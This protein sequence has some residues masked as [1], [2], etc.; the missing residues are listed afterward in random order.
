MNGAVKYIIHSTPNHANTNLKRFLAYIK[1][2]G[3]R[4]V[5]LV[6]HRKQLFCNKLEIGR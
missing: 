5:T 1:L 3:K 2:L 6:M 4:R